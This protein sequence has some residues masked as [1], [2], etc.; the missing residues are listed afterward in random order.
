[1]S[2]LVCASGALAQ[3][4]GFQGGEIN[5]SFAGYDNENFDNPVNNFSANFATAYNISPSLGVQVGAGY[6]SFSL[7]EGNTAASF[8]MTDL[9]A[10]AYYN[11]GE[12]GKA[13]VF[14]ARY[15][16]SNL[17]LEQ[18]GGPGTAVFPIGSDLLTYGL[19]GA[20]EFGGVNVELRYG[21]AE[22]QNSILLDLIGDRDLHIPIEDASYFFYNCKCGLRNFSK[23]GNYGA[24]RKYPYCL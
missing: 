21:M 11:F 9:N 4:T 2:I 24:P 10:H 8:D 1:M 7:K 18:I 14:V 22:L 3:D 16:L 13:G 12:N 6:N 5:I 15:S 17:F 23:A 20:M 19:E